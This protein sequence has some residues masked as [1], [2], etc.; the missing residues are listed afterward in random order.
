MASF[1]LLAAATG[2][3]LI[4]SDFAHN[5]DLRFTERR[6][7]RHKHI[8]HSRVKCVTSEHQL[9]RAAGETKSKVMTAANLCI[10]C[11]H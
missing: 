11:L 7:N 1:E 6:S 8:A 3:L 5:V 9:A 2:T 10:V 4:P